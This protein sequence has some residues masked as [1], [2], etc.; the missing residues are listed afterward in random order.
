MAV[1]LIGLYEIG[2][3]VAKLAEKKRPKTE[4]LKDNQGEI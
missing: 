3:L 1:P 2:I 4:D